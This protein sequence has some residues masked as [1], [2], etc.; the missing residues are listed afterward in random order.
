M[1]REEQATVAQPVLSSG[2]PMDTQ[3]IEEDQE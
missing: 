3:G 1:W 2:R